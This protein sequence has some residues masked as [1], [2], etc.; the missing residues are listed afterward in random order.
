MVFFKSLYDC[1]DKCADRNDSCAL[2]WHSSVVSL[3][4]SSGIV[5][6]AYTIIIITKSKETHRFDGRIQ[7]QY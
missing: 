4:L 6:R 2:V 7:N 5:D 3:F 1:Q